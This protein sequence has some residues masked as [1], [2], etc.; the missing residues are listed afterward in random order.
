MS[1][2]LHISQYFTFFL[3]VLTLGVMHIIG[4]YDSPMLALLTAFI[5]YIIVFYFLLSGNYAKSFLY[6]IAFTATVL[7]YDF[8]IFGEADPTTI[9]YSFAILPVVKPYLRYLL[10]FVF[11]A[12]SFKEYISQK[13]V[14]PPALASLKKWIIFLFITGVISIFVG[15]LLNDNGMRNFPDIYPKVAYIN[16]LYFCYRAC[17]IFTAIHLIRRE[18]WKEECSSYIQIVLLSVV[19]ITTIAVILGYVGHYGV[20]E[21]L[22]A[23]ISVALTPLL[24]LFALKRQNIISYKVLTAAGILIILLSILYGGTAMGSKWYIIIMLAVIGCVII[25]AKIQNITTFAIGAI[26]VILLIPSISALIL[27]YID[28][29]THAGF[30]IAQALNTINIFQKTNMSDWYLHMDDSP[31]YRIDE[32]HNTIIEYIKKPGYMLFGKGIGGSIQHYTTLLSWDETHAFSED[33]IRMSAYYNMHESLAVIFLQHGIVGLVFFV[34]I[35]Y[36]IM[37]R[38]SKTPWA[39]MSLVWFFFYWNY[40]IALLIG[41]VILVITLSDEDS[42]EPQVVKNDE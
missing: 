3:T 30:K 35:I 26:A 17:I 11:A 8:F 38:L 32:L 6:Y 13:Y 27:P 19:L 16:I 31:L 41:S 36:L 24:V 9:H 23:P 7:E 29:N 18:G 15:F 40:S 5:Q 37:K 28:I 25:I 34:K 42:Q 14:L 39:M 2:K 10:A 1:G 33:Q 22:T 4:T 21:I 12:M 20:G